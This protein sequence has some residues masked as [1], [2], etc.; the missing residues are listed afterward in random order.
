MTDNSKDNDDRP[1]SAK[2]AVEI[3]VDRYSSKMRDVETWKESAKAAGATLLG[4]EAAGK[5]K[6]RE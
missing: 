5:F 1:V 3:F 6:K 2:E 4:E